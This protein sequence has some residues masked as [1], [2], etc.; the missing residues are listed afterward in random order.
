MR[1]TWKRQCEIIALMR[2]L[3]TFYGCLIFSLI[4]LLSTTEAAAQMPFKSSHQLASNKLI[5]DKVNTPKSQL[6]GNK[7]K[8]TSRVITDRPN[9]ELKT[10]NRTGQYN[11]VS[12][13]YLTCA[14][15]DGNR[16]DIVYGEN[17]KV[18]LK[19]ILCGAANY[20]GTDSWVEGTIEGNEIHVALGQSIYWSDQY[21]A[22]VLLAWG[23][24]GIDEAG[25][26]Y[27]TR[28]E[29]PE[30]AVY[31][32]DGQTISLQGSEGS[33]GGDSSVEADY[34]GIG[35]TAYWE[36]DD[37]WTGY[38][39]WN[40]VLTE[41]EPVVTPEV[42]TG[43]PDGCTIYTY[44]RNSGYIANRDFF[45]GITH[46]ATQGTFSVAI[47]MRNDD[48]YIQNPAW[49]Y[50]GLN[51]W[52]K[53]TYD[54]ETGIITVPA[55]QFL[56]WF[57]QDEYGFQL[58]WGSSYVYQDGE[59]EDGNPAYY[60]ETSIDESTTEIL[61]MVDGDYLYLLGTEGDVTAEFPEWGNAT[62]LM[63]IYSDDQSWT[64]FEFANRDENGYAEPMGYYDGEVPP[65]NSVNLTVSLPEATDCS[66]YANMD[67]AIKNSQDNKTVHFV[68]TN[69]RSYMF[70][71]VHC[72]TTWNVTLTNQYGDIFG[73]IENVKVGGTGVNVSFS[74]L[75]KPHDV[76]LT[77]KTPD[78]QDVTSQCKISWLDENG[79]LLTQGNQIKKLPAGRKLKYEVSLP[80]ELAT[81]YT[82][83]A[84]NTYTVKSSSNNVVCQLTA[85]SQ[86]RLSGK[87][88]D[89]SN[90]QPL[91]GATISA[92]Q[93]F[94]DNNTKTLTAR[95]DNQGRYSLEASMVPT[96]LTVAAPG[97]INKTIDCDLASGSTITVPDVALSPITGAVVNVNLTF[98]PAHLQSNPAEAQA[99][100]SDYNNVDYV[101]YNKTTGRSISNIS[102][103]YPQI[104]L[105]ED[106]SDGDVL[107]ITATSRTGAFNP[108]KATVTID[109][110]KATATFNILE[111]GKLSSKFKKNI[112]P[113]VVGILYDEE[114]KMVKSNNYAGDTLTMDDLADGSY[115]LIT[116]GKCEFFNGIYDMDQYA[117]AGL[118]SDVDYAENSVT[119]TNGLISPVTINEVPY[120][121]ETKFYYT[122]EGTSFSVNKPDI[123]VGNYLT[124]RAQVDFKEQYSDKI[125]DVQIIVDLPES[126][127]FYENS[128]MVGSNMG[129]YTIIGNQI[130]IPIVNTEHIVCFCAIPTVPGDFSPS[131]FV[132][133]KLNGKTITQPIGQ[134]PF[135]A[136]GLSI[137]VPSTVAKTEITVSGTAIGTCGID[138]F[139]NDVLI[140][141]TT[142]LAN[143]TWSTKCELNEPYNL[144][145]HRIHALV[146]TTQ[147]IVLQT[148][149]S[150][151][152]YDKNAIEVDNVV[153]SFY[154][155]WLRENVTVTFDFL[156]GKVSPNSYQ[157]YT[158]T[159][160]TF[161]TN[162][163]SNDTAIVS[164]VIVNVFTDHN[165]THRLPA[166]YDENSNRWVA[167]AYFSSNDLPV[168][169][170]VDYSANT[171]QIFSSTHLN[172]VLSEAKSEYDQYVQGRN[173]I[174]EM[175]A[176]AWTAI[177]DAGDNTDALL[178]AY[179][180]F[181]DVIGQIND[182]YNLGIDLQP[183]SEYDI[184]SEEELEATEEEDSIRMLTLLQ[185]LEQE[186]EY[187][188]KTYI[189]QEY[190]DFVDQQNGITLSST[191]C[192]GLYPAYL[193]EHGYEAILTDN[194]DSIYVKFGSDTVS[195]VNFEENICQTIVLSD[196]G[197][198][199]MFASTIFELASSEESSDLIEELKV[200]FN[201]IK[202]KKKLADQI[203]EV[204]GRATVNSI[205]D[206][207]TAML[208]NCNNLVG[209]FKELSK[210]LF[211]FVDKAKDTKLFAP[212]KSLQD[213]YNRLHKEW[214]LAKAHAARS[215]NIY[216]HLYW[217]SIAARLEGKLPQ[218]KFLLKSGKFLVRYA[219]V[220]AVA[221][222][223]ADAAEK[224]FTVVGAASTIF[225]CEDDIL[226]ACYTMI[227]AIGIVRN[228]GHYAGANIAV[229]VAFDGTALAASETVLGAVGIIAL[230]YIASWGVQKATDW[231]FNSKMNTL[232]NKIGALKCQIKPQPEPS[233]PKTPPTTPVHDPSGFVYE[234]VPSNRLQG[235]T[236]TCYYKETVE[237]MYGDP[238]EN[239]VLWDAEQ[240]GQENPLLT[241]ENGF[242]RWDVPI[243]MWQV[244]Y[245][246]EGYET[247][248][249]DWL[250][251]PPPQLDVNIG[252]VQMRQPEVIKARAYPQA[253]ELEFDKFMF[254]ETLTTD[255]ITVSVNGTPVSGSIELLDAEVDDPLAITSIRRAPGTGLTFASR[256][257]FNADR[258]FNADKV[259]LHV[260]QDVK[261]YADL[262][263]NGDYEAV[264][265]IEL[266]IK[267]IEADSTVNVIYGDSRELTVTVLPAAA[268][269]G[270]TLTVRSIAPMIATTDAETYTINN[271]G[272]AVITVHGD[273]PGMTSL[274]YGID[275]YDLTAN[276]LVN[277]MMES[278]MTVATPTA[279][280]AS[281]STVEEGTAVY[282]RCAT[283]GATIY[284]TLDGSCP[285]DPSPARKV[286][287][288]TP[289][290]IN[291]T[292]TIK[293][294]ATAPDLYDSEVATFVYR[295]GNG[296][297]GDVNGD[298]EVNI[299]D[300]NAAIDIILGSSVDVQTRDRADVN[301]D[302]EVN[303]ADINA[304]VD[305][306]LSPS[307]MI[308]L[309]VN[310]D[311]LVHIDDVT[312]K[313]GDVR[314]LQVTV[315]NAARYSAMQ[316]DIVLPDGL[317]LVD[318]DAMGLN[319]V[320]TGSLDGY[321][322]RVVN[323]SM[324]KTPF[325]GGMQ[326]V[327]TITVKADAAL[328]PQSEIALTHVVLADADNKAWHLNDCVARVNNASGINDMTAIANRVWMEDRTLYIESSQDGIAQIVTMDG[329]VRNFA[330]KIGKNS[331]DLEPGIY[332]V[333][334][335]GK[336]YKVAV[337]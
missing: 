74:S 221:F 153:M 87:V 21:Q 324:N 265:P 102:A 233:E 70:T 125:N 230:K 33:T 131:A 291:S 271:N 65:F 98:T 274:V 22:N 149:I 200:I 145:T 336:S 330:I 121:D 203:L 85:I 14:Q 187:I 120:F 191:T 267:S 34:H 222:A 298:G 140:G 51:T 148:E 176:N 194:G 258:P 232:Y 189:Y 213:K 1:R 188:K 77:V 13:G 75:L 210:L 46:G 6:K 165:N 93:S 231:H 260:K 262:M 307:N 312:M 7:K 32:I 63:T 175:L 127:H 113:Q 326:P 199:I 90:N 287:D 147:G 103:Q 172:D 285:C 196:I 263:M 16:M 290:V 130:I 251:V 279:T 318:V 299:A 138:I 39:E 308:S 246:K 208:A 60:L 78:G 303:I 268:S 11:Y 134:S 239:V 110:Q 275:G 66:E 69:N 266:E 19:N 17:G 30:E 23:E 316:C 83:P 259:T 229:D 54:A 250:P 209:T 15:Q 278:Q 48:V 235:V 168:N 201:K 53:G 272:K 328:A 264:L 156:N 311:D 44:D 244:K 49:W 216:R 325:A 123:V 178:A 173:D 99:W 241:D 310:S 150:D 106:V 27:F 64:S 58:V 139:D 253:V 155:G 111:K 321:T 154:N 72:N 186:I 169:V 97:Y 254:P 284:Y 177:E 207:Y 5:N 107:E 129:G 2:K 319:T 115:K 10:Y 142:S 228:I 41:R 269:K 171:E 128:V 247:T 335:N 329:V 31:V 62:G 24:A 80:Q 204:L 73:K 116:M 160:F 25:S 211:D 95:T 162:F 224:I 136:K 282:L 91:Y 133:F 242:Y 288:G 236:A 82:L 9:G 40:T 300:V 295:I 277:V 71:G 192:D 157:F 36:D 117:A 292:V 283:E 132:Q 302:G 197:K 240:Y 206:D 248:Y 76:T 37:S 249:S 79:E 205:K 237:D 108:V 166:V 144:S 238:V 190:S 215:K 124:F 122:G 280:I 320:K 126:C 293:A 252:M 185:E 135:T 26:F 119:V 164:D 225:P 105:M 202:E 219:P 276:T 317:T 170:S 101:V 143:G 3:I 158:D 286:Y 179:D 301:S 86:T 81:A 256:V 255:N 217:K 89:E 309:R 257:R 96:T 305:M 100:Y 112:N 315:D 29:H 57:D 167:S 118:Q 28:D 226:N 183:S 180:S 304:L 313:P 43:I 218:T 289:I 163:T 337:K 137:N 38:L 59:D 55:G 198:S 322:S 182:I 141:H 214:S 261:S 334:L 92:V 161:V 152:F 323:Y 151:C 294:M 331:Q 61:F 273:L 159:N 67:L 35:L 297:A 245:E 20:F 212:L 184:L 195:Y 12:S 270:K 220:A 333:V 306:I 114:N 234:G 146:T 84:T 94:G 332:V 56:A 47:D 4:L 281:G 8:P 296:I 181:D 314:T 327:M 18:Y 88:K 193:L 50:D 104:V 109:G 52:I 42:I 223:V 45:H 243:G 227:Y 174:D 68:V